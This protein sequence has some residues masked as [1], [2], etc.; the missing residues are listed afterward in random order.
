MMFRS[1]SASITLAVTLS[2]A[3][4]TRALAAA[5]PAAAVL[6]LSFRLFTAMGFATRDRGS[7]DSAAVH[8]RC[9]PCIRP[10]SGP[11]VH[12]LCRRRGRFLDGTGFTLRRVISNVARS[13]RHSTRVNELS[14][15]GGRIARALAAGGHAIDDLDR[16]LTAGQ[17]IGAAQERN[18]LRQQRDR[19]VEIA[20]D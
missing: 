13:L 16:L 11:D 17:A 14:G 10:C 5:M 3:A 2:S 18:A 19:A 15:R 1:A 12:S 8:S 4:F 7:M 6:G 9:A 20:G